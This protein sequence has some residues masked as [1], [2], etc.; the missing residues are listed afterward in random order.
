LP[1]SFTGAKLYD[2]SVA[3]CAAIDTTGSFVAPTRSTRE[4]FEM[5][6][7]AAHPDLVDADAL[8]SRGNHA[9]L[10]LRVR[11]HDTIT[12]KE[13]EFVDALRLRC[14][15]PLVPNHV[16]CF[17]GAPLP[18]T[19]ASSSHL[20]RCSSVNGVTWKARHDDV[21]GVLCRA[22]SSSGSSVIREP[23]FYNYEDGRANRPDLTAHLA[24]SSIAVDVTIVS[25]K[26]NAGQAAREAA[27]EKIEK[28]AAA[29]ETYG[30][31][32]MALSFESGGHADPAF[33][34]FCRAIGAAAPA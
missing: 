23:T 24:G 10:W 1:H 19:H 22:V 6:L 7:S 20:L 26:A 5:E 13:S 4:A 8:S 17:C 12:V 3:A 27:D 32:F 34:R 14:R 2:E 18:P 25:A 9:S 21:C 31:T 16:V 33:D 15:V 11:P 28:H 29:V 30:H